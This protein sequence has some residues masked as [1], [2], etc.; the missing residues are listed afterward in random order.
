MVH[1]IH[2]VVTRVIECWPIN[3]FWMVEVEVMAD[4]QYF[5]TDISVCTELEARAIQ[6]GDSV[7]IPVVSLILRAELV[8]WQ[9]HDCVCL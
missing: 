4:G 5:R 8:A 1:E 6:S 9:S 7:L 3:D 2:A